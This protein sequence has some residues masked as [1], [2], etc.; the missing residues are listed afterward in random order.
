MKLLVN[1]KAVSS[2]ADVCSEIDAFDPDCEPGEDVR[3]IS[4]AEHS[5]EIIALAVGW[6]EA[7]RDN[8]V[9]AAKKVVF[10]SD[11]KL[12]ESNGVDAVLVA[13]QAA[14]NVFSLYGN[15]GLLLPGKYGFPSFSTILEEDVKED[16]RQRPE[17]YTLYEFSVN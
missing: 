16:I 11:K 14:M 10:T 8:L 13:A 15:C 6:N 1:N 17:N 7:L 5:S 3:V 4:G 12:R 2:Y 9:A